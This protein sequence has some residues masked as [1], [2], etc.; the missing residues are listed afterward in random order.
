MK[1]VQF[2]VLSSEPMMSEDQIK[3]NLQGITAISAALPH[4]VQS[5]KQPPS[6]PYRPQSTLPPPIQLPKIRHLDHHERVKNSVD[7]S[8]HR[9]MF[10]CCCSF[11]YYLIHPSITLMFGCLA[12]PAVTLGCVFWL[13]AVCFVS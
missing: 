2:Q 9:D 8:N 6:T 5:V 12:P 10:L 11:Y 1:L 7:G 4:T 13:P 3:V